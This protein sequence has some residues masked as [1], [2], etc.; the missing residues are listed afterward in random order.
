MRLHEISPG[1]FGTTGTWWSAPA[2]QGP[3][4]S[5]Y[6]V[7]DTAGAPLSAQTY[8]GFLAKDARDAPGGPVLAGGSTGIGLWWW[9]TCKLDTLG[10]LQWAH[11]YDPG[12]G[13]SWTENPRPAIPIPQGGYLVSNIRF[14]G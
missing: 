4:L 9:G 11:T 12:A 1:K 13:H 2:L 3:F 5:A 6:V 14:A 10:A 7:W 8:T